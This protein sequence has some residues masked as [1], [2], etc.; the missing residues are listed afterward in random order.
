MTTIEGSSTNKEIREEECTR[1]E[2]KYHYS[3][4]ANI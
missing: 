4:S 3:F 2:E 1:E